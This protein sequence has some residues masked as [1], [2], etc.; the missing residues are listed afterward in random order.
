MQSDLVGNKKVWGVIQ[1][2]Y[3]EAKSRV[4]IKNQLSNE[5]GVN[6]GVHQGS[7]LSPLLFILLLEALSRELRTGVPW[8]LF[9]AYDLV[10]IS[11]SLDDCISKFKKWKLE[12]ESKGLQVNSKKTKLMMNSRAF[13]CMVC[14]KCRR[15][16]NFCFTCS[17][18]ANKRCSV[19]LR[20]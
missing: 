19:R 16:L 7:V 3:V 1:S 20:H 17:H 13:S 11:V 10:L 15:H 9:Y 6:V 8:E 18:W 12:I 2:M 14:S 4:R 5:F